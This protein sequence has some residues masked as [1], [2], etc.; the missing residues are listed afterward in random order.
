MLLKSN[1][2]MSQDSS[3]SPSNHNLW[4][5]FITHSVLEIR[6]FLNWLNST[7]IPKSCLKLDHFNTNL[8]KIYRPNQDLNWPS[9]S[10]T[11][12]SRFFPLNC[13]LSAG[14]SQKSET[15]DLFFKAKK[16]V[17]NAS[18][19]SD[20]D[21]WNQT[22]LSGVMLVLNTKQSCFQH[23]VWK[24]YLKTCLCPIGWWWHNVLS[25][26]NIHNQFTTYFL[27]KMMSACP[28]FEIHKVESNTGTTAMAR[29]FYVSAL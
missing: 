13:T 8:G 2:N 17:G 21:L 1:E 14:K 11:G 29:Y 28:Q 24:N 4:K 6:I 16:W 19:S 7:K 18:W 27:P 23:R 26:T 12:L 9:S 10:V 3:L 15:T 22:F 20:L 5:Y 25:W